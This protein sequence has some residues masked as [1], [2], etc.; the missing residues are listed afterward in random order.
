MRIATVTP[1]RNRLG[2]LY[3]HLKSLSVQSR[4]P[5]RV[6]VSSHGD[7]EE[8]SRSIVSMLDR[9]IASA[10]IPKQF[11]RVAEESDPW[12]KPLAVNFAVRRTEPDIDVVAVFDVDMILHPETLAQVELALEEND[13]RYVMC[14]NLSLPPKTPDGPVWTYDELRKQS[15]IIHWKG[16]R[17]RLGPPLMGWGALQAARR[18]WWFRV[19]GLDEDMKLWGIED[20]DMAKRAHKTGLK[21]HWLKRRYALLH[22]WHEP[23]QVGNK[24]AKRQKFRNEEISFRKLKRFEYVRNDSNWGGGQYT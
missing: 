14:S 24:E 6:I 9:H 8:S 2:Q 13:K 1:H 22:Q 3:H 20:Y 12:C 15:T 19:R 4:P 21:W 7:N 18:D 16:H 17:K 23:G 11:W 5:D 10:D